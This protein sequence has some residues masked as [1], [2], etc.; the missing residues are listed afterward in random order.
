MHC[1]Q[2]AQRCTTFVYLVGLAAWHA[3]SSGTFNSLSK[4]LCTFPSWYLFA[5]GFEAILRFRW[6]I[7]PALRSRPKEH[8]SE[9]TNWTPKT[10]RDERDSHPSLYSVPEV[11]TL[12][13]RLIS[14]LYTTLQTLQPAVHYDQ[15][16]VH[17]PL[18]NKSYLV[19][20][21]PLTYMLKFSGYSHLAQVL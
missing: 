10:T 20:F 3:T 5:I 19:S 14:R 18:I 7:P 4:V 21:P 17:S 1:T 2:R 8:D 6:N 9:N 15:F 16:V 13:I 12:V 11:F